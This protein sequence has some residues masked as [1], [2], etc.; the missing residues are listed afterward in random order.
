MIWKPERSLGVLIGISLILLVLL[1]DFSLFLRLLRLPINLTSFFLGLAILLSLPILAILGYW[2][3]GLFNM[4]YYLDRNGLIINWGAMKQ[5]IPI[6]SIISV[7]RGEEIKGKAGFGGMKWL[8]Y[9]VGRG[10]VEGVGDVIFYATKP[11]SKQILLVTPSISYSISPPNTDAFLEAFE[12]RHRL[13]PIKPLKLETIQARFK[14]WPIWSDRV[15]HLLMA[16]GLILNLSL[17]AYIFWIYPALPWL[18]PLHF[19][20]FGRVERVGV[21]GEILRLPLGG[22]LFFL[23]NSAFS[24]L[25]HRRERVG[26][27]LLWGGAILVQFLLWL[28]TLNIVG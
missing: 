5:I 16:L 13:G 12:A 26:A 7:M 18:L 17:F 6:G 1:F 3:Y 14:N 28:A 2:L 10:K 23:T 8:G 21:K 4:S 9:W 22:L 20:A 11:F 27:Y 19:N 15:A 25:I 24:L